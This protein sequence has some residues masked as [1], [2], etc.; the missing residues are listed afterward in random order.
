ML[1]QANIEKKE[2]NTH[3][4]LYTT[5][6]ISIDKY[7]LRINLVPGRGDSAKMA[8]FGLFWNRKNTL[9]KIA[10]IVY[11]AFWVRKDEIFMIFKFYHN[12]YVLESLSF[13]AIL[14]R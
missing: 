1:S 9:L 11:M 8:S 6:S 10:R 3:L 7:L 2:S 12:Y 14:C 5:A 4:F 13:D